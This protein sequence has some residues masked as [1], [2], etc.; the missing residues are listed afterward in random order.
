MGLPLSSLVEALETLAPP[1]LAEA[2]DN[3]G[4]LVDPRAAGEELSVE[5]VLLTI[6]ATPAVLEEAARSGAQCL[7]AY[8]PPLFRPQ[9]RLA[10]Q[11]DAVV[12][13]AVRH[14][15]AVYSPHTALDAAPGGVNDWLAEAFGEAEVRALF[16]SE[17]SEPDA[18]LKLVVFVPAA[19]VDE[20]RSAL[21]EAGAGVIGSY[22][23]CSFNIAG[24][25]T[26]YG[27]EGAAP[28]VGVAGRLE[29]APEVRLEMVCSR[30]ALPRAAQ[31]IERHHPYETPAWEVY[32]LAPKA[33]AGTGIGRSVTLQAPTEL[34]DIVSMLKRHLALDHVRVA[35]A[36]HHTAGAPVRTIAVCAGAGSSVF[37]R[38]S[39]VDLYVTGELGHH[40]V[41]AKL[42]GGSSVI[43]TEHSS[44]ERGYLP[45]LRERLLAAARGAVDVQLASADIEPLRVV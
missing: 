12:F 8:H 35:A 39:G 4:L 20:L 23:Q 24:E 41:L 1:S 2:W 16:P 36:P 37:E 6:D 34:G 11:R 43:L 10:L 28:V 32:P 3:V 22:T 40:H 15:M 30:R 33:H 38:V 45:R 18:Q 26:F 31:A 42:S 9:K 27:Q 19:A 44:S 13:H 7:V 5:R 29:R 14:G 25:G 17:L 21:A